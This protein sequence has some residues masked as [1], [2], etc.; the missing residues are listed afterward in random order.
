MIVIFGKVIRFYLGDNVVKRYDKK[1][2]MDWDC[3][4]YVMLNVL[5]MWSD[6]M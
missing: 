1:V 2:K 4:C 3:G 5:G 6:N